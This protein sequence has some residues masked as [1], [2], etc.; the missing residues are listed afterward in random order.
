MNNHLFTAL[1]MN[2][3]VISTLSAMDSSARIK[4]NSRHNF[5]EK[6]ITKFV[7]RGTKAP[8]NTPREINLN[9]ALHFE[10][11]DGTQPEAISMNQRIVQEIATLQKES[12][13]QSQEIARLQAEIAI[14]HEKL[15]F[16]LGKNKLEEILKI[17]AELAQ[18]NTKLISKT[19]ALLRAAA[20]E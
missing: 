16:E 4:W 20:R 13:H 1:I 3:I 6:K 12:A 10:L 17:H 18:I 2:S 8:Q 9:G 14:A 15:D 19:Q 11:Q 5:T 7:P